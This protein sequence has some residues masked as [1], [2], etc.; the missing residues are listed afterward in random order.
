[1]HIPKNYF[2]DRAILFLLTVNSFVVVLSSLSIMFRLGSN[3]DGLTGQYR[4]NLGLKS[5]IPGDTSVFVGFM[6]FLVFV[7][8]F[9]TVM[10]MRVYHIRHHFSRAILALG[11]LL[12]VSAAIVSNALLGL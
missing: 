3:R 10:S 5:F 6:L 2:H 4:S 11:L 8:V 7:L 12:I 1:M 9:H